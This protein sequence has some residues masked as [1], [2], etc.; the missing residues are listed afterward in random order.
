MKEDTR[1]C[2]VASET[3]GDGDEKEPT[4]CARNELHEHC[5]NGIANRISLAVSVG[6]RV[7]MRGECM[8]VHAN[9]SNRVHGDRA[10]SYGTLS[11]EHAHTHTHMHTHIHTHTRGATILL[12]LYLIFRSIDVTHRE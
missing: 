3:D 5:D 8:C 2:N 10:M 1:Y 4:S 9:C 12:S 7:L 6:E 11:Q